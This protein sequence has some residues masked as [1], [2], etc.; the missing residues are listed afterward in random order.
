MA[1]TNALNMDENK[2]ESVIC[3]CDLEYASVACNRTPL[4]LDWGRNGWVAF[5]AC[6][7]V[8]LCCP[9]VRRCLKLV[10]HV[11]RNLDLF[12]H[13]PLRSSFK[14]TKGDENELVSGSTDKSVR[15]W[16]RVL[17]VEGNIH[18]KISDV[19]EG[20]QGAVNSVAGI[21]ISLPKKEESRTV[22][23]SASADSTI[24]IWDRKGTGDHFSCLQ[25]VSF[26]N[27]F[28]LALAVSI[29]PGTTVL[30]MTD[31]ETFSQPLSLLSASMDK[32][33][34]LWSPDEDSGVWI[35]KVRVGE[36]GGTTLGFYGGVFSPDGRSILGHGYQG[37]FRLWNKIESQGGS[38]WEPSV[39]VSGHFGP[40]QDIDWDPVDGQFLVSVSSDQTTRL[41]APWRLDTAKRHENLPVGASVPALG[42]SNKAVFEGDIESLK[43]DLEDPARPMKSSA[44]ASEEP[45][46]FTPLS[47]KE[48]PTEDVLLQNTLWPEVQKL[49]GHGYEV[50]CVASSPDGALLASACKASKSEHA[51]L[52]LWDTETWRQVCSLASHALTV[53]Q[54]AF[55]HGGQRLLSV[56]R[57]RCWSVFKRKRE[58]DEGPLFQLVARS[59]KSRQHARII[60]SCAWSG[61]DKYFATASRDKKVIMWGDQ[62]P[63]KDN[64]QAVCK[65]L[66]VGEPATA[67]D[68]G[69]GIIKGLRYLVAV[70]TESGRIA[71]YSW[72]MRP[73]ADWNKLLTLD[74]SISHVLTVRRL[75]WRPFKDNKS[76]RLQ[77]ASCSLDH[78]VRI[79]NVVL[80]T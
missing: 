42:L 62:E 43:R 20:H 23:A 73:V 54:M 14:K 55:D 66:D 51:V 39:A 78:S 80:T 25:T 44:F 64:W 72:A 11:H 74:Q 58:S 57:D 27:G 60:W 35:E 76:F 8:A 32:T 13:Y 3:K 38:R 36:V 53:T 5:G 59:D 1:D 2:T 24:K 30:I 68:I 46:P 47:L 4:C 16:Q 56:S 28:I 71:L 17:D 49:Y 50:Y 69:P 37:A 33:L 7:S 79:Y 29:L 21:N 41:H 77:L 75:K 22:I 19:L 65:P 12:P 45:A 40:V 48:P 6:Y 70:G 15:V 61:D 9:E 18:W 10:Y 31:D 63:P 67:I 52:I 26:G 34:M